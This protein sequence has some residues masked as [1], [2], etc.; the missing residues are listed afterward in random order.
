LAAVLFLVDKQDLVAQVVRCISKA[1]GQP[2]AENKT[3]AARDL[4]KMFSNLICMSVRD[5]LMTKPVAIKEGEDVVQADEQ[6]IVV[7]LLN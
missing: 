5:F 7:D 4:F 6:T 2:S 3:F 1:G